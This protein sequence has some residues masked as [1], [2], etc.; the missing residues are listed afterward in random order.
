MKIPVYLITGCLEAGKTRFIQETL[1]GQLA[2]PRVGGRR[3]ARGAWSLPVAGLQSGWVGVEGGLPQAQLWLL[4]PGPVPSLPRAVC[5][6]SPPHPGPLTGCPFCSDSLW[7][8]GGS[9]PG[10]GKDVHPALV[11]GRLQVSKKLCSSRTPLGDPELSRHPHYSM[12][13]F[14]GVGCP[15]HPAHPRLSWLQGPGWVGYGSCKD[16]FCDGAWRE[17]GRRWCSALPPMLSL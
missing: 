11:S 6:A 10:P 3:K 17:A 8:Y 12:G 13:A 2:R 4:L 16:A 15:G 9:R 1:M 5:S 14:H 7:V